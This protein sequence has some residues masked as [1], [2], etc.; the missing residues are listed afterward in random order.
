VRELRGVRGEDRGVSS[1]PG[2]GDQ[3]S[4]REHH[5]RDR[6]DA[7]D[8]QTGHGHLHSRHHGACVRQAERHDPGQ[9]PDAPREHGSGRRRSQPHARTEQRAGRLRHGS[10]S[11]HVLRLPEG[12]FAG[13][14]QKIRRFLG[15]GQH[16]GKAGAEDRRNDQRTAHG[17][18]EGLLDLRRE[19][20]GH[21]A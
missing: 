19:P 20:G 12:G 6:A 10:P 17:Q 11:Q 21:G 1:Q 4:P 8:R 7:R 18:A 2:L 14:Q 5:R 13:D 3:R 15:R 9:P 16:S